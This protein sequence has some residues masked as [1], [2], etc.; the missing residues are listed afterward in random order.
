MWDQKILV[1]MLNWKDIYN[2]EIQDT[3][4]VASIFPSDNDFIR[5]SISNPSIL[6]DISSFISPLKICRKSLVI[7]LSK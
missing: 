5:N 2:S 4:I 3:G 6:I 1:Y 7:S